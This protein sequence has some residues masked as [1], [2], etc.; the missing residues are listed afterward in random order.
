MVKVGRTALDPAK[1]ARELRTTGVPGRFKVS[2][3]TWTSDAARSEATAH[4]L[5]AGK[6]VAKDREF[7]RVGERRAAQ[8]VAR[9]CGRRR[10]PG[11]AWLAVVVLSALG[12]WTWT[13]G[14][15]GSH[16]A[17]LRLLNNTR[18]LWTS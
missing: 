14:W 9:A 5:L 2:Y 4:K 8:V 13:Q 6:R 16:Q 7:F 11:V 1:R 10:M 3:S 18:F 12:A 15:T 17:M